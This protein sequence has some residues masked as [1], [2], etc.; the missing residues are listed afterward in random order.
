MKSER[1]YIT[2]IEVFSERHR[3]IQWLGM[4]ARRAQGIVR[5]RSQSKL[6]QQLHLPIRHKSSQVGFL[7]DDPYIPRY[8]LLTPL[9]ESRKRTE[10][11]AHLRECNLCPRL[12]GK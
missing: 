10:A 2:S 3:K 6:V 12:C 5:L 4:L 8:Q 9:Q 1:T 11:Y 7:V